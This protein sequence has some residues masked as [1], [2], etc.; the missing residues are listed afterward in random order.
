MKIGQAAGGRFF[1]DPRSLIPDPHFQESILL[2]G[3]RSAR[4]KIRLGYTT[5]TFVRPYGVASS[6]ACLVISVKTLLA[7]TIHL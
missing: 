4:Q 7:L 5:V 6:Q 3:R 2:T 1:S